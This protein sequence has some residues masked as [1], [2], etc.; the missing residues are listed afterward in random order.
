MKSLIKKIINMEVKRV[1]KNNYNC[2]PA[3]YY[4]SKKPIK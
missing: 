4:K 3:N 1:R 2:S